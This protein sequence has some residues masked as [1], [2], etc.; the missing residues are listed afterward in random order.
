MMHFQG[1]D[2]AFSLFASFL[3]ECV[4]VCVG[5]WRGGGEGVESTF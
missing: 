4:Y 2:S 1:R 5:G 3:K